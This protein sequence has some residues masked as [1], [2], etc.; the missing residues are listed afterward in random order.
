MPP[1]SKFRTPK[2]YRKWSAC[3]IHERTDRRSEFGRARGRS[4]DGRL[5]LSRVLAE[6]V[7]DLLFLGGFGG[8]RFGFGCG[9]SR[10]LRGLRPKEFRGIEERPAHRW[11]K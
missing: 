4:G 5:S 8:F 6:E 1:N 11:V 3:A 7:S 9:G 2:L 10:I